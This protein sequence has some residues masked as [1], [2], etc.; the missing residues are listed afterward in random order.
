MEE[1]VIPAAWAPIDKLETAEGVM[2]GSSGMEEVI[3]M[4]PVSVADALSVMVSVIMSIIESDIIPGIEVVVAAAE[5]DRIL[6]E[7][8]SV[9]RGVALSF[10]TSSTI[11]W[12][13]ASDMSSS[14]ES[15]MLFS[16][17]CEEAA[18]LQSGWMTPVSA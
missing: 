13:S 18:G 5:D 16:I 8:E 10:M 1:E 17:D 14:T 9:G 11:I 2:V 7:A 4:T 12:G 3:D 6:A 15:D